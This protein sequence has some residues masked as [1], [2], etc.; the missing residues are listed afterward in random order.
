MTLEQVLRDQRPNKNAN[1]LKCDKVEVVC[2]VVTW[3]SGSTPPPPTHTHQ[4][5]CVANGKAC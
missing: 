5:E 2:I 3:C 1:H 4:K